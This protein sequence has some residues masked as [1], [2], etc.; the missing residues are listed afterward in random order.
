MNKN[1][2]TLTLGKGRNKR[3]WQLTKEEFARFESMFEECELID[4]SEYGSGDWKITVEKGGA[5]A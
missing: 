4:P 1:V 3:Q 2:K 5:N